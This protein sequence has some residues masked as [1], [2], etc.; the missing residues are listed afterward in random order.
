VHA[1]STPEVG[2]G[3]PRPRLHAVFA[4]GGVGWDPGG[5]VVDDV[6][7]A[8]T[9]EVADPLGD[10]ERLGWWGLELTGHGI[11]GKVRVSLGLPRLFQGATGPN[12]RGHIEGLY[13]AFG[14]GDL[15]GGLYWLMRAIGSHLGGSSCE[16]GCDE[17]QIASAGS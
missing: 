9:T 14:F 11:G 2:A 10:R 4:L 16:E 17:H 7:L 13:L 12:L 3:G 6:H 8:L 15:N 5:R 1:G